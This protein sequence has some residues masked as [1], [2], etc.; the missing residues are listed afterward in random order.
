MHNKNLILD[1]FNVERKT[2]LIT[3]GGSGLGKI[4][5]ETLCYSGANVFIASRKKEVVEKAAKTIMDKKPAGSVTALSAD[6]G[7][8]KSINE[9]IKTIEG[10]TERLDI[11][12]NNAGRSWGAELGQFPY[13]AWEKILAVNV[14]GLFHLTQGLLPLLKKTATK[15]EPARIINVGSVMGTAALGDGAY[16]YSA[17]K[18]AVHQLTR[19]LAKELAKYHITCNALA[20]GPFSSAMTDFALNNEKKETSVS[21]GIPLGRIGENSDISGSILYLCSTA[22]KYL[23]G[24]ILPI[25]GGLHIAT[26]PELFAEAKKLK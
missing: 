5:T 25:D 13:L 19:I 2:V 24:A 8:E 21:S 18:A 16:S 20:P 10:S 11:L 17:S 9:L 4:M 12:I 14:A 26:G 7:D 3:G 15:T 1:L 6:I 23:T 22:G